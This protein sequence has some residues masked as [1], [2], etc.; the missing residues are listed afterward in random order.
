[1]RA[2]R[3]TLGCTLAVALAACAT[4][5]VTGKREISLVS[6]DQEIQMGQQG[7]QQVAQEIGLINDQALQNYVQQVGIALAQKSERPNLPW[8]FRAVDDPTPNAFALPGGFIFITRGLLDLMGNEAELASVLGHEIG[9]VTARHSVQQMSQQQLAQLALGVGAIISPT[10]AQFGDIAAQGLG[11]LF[12]KY[13]RDDERQADDLGFRYALNQGYDVREMDD[14][15]RSLQRIG[16]TS[17]QS[18][19]PTWLAT[20][21][22][23]AERIQTIDAKVAQLQ[24]AQ[25]ANAKVGTQEFA[26]RINGLVYGANP[27][28]GFFQGSTFYHPDLR[29]QMTLPSGWQGQ[30]LTQAVVAVSPQ[31]DAIIQLT[32]AEG[33]SPESAAQKFL[34]QQ[35]IQAGQ[36]SRETVNGVPAVAS[37]FQAQT[38][39]GVIQGLVAFF[40]YN[41][42]T[43]QVISYTPQQKYSTYANVFRQSLGSFGP[44]TDQRILSVQPNKVSIVTLQQPMTLTEFAQRYPSAIPIAELAIVNQVESPTTP[45]PAGTALKQIAGGRTG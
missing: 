4:N 43:Y 37:T 2:L 28:Q 5:P 15:F 27:R 16:E 10:V 29:F 38:E 19:L 26:Q 11:L 6:Q 45:I 34:S 9:H 35:G 40:T 30:N 12:L 8:T 22:G 7:A 25:L 42:T 23:E 39:Q 3:N 41:G 44:L 14:V 1:M 32:L 33:S 17:K 21:P 20:H 36:A 18:P 31:Q 24:P 13:G